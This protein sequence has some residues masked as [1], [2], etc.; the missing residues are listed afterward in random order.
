MACCVSNK[1]MMLH[2]YVPMHILSEPL[3]LYQ[4]AL[5][6]D[7]SRAL[8]NADG[9][10]PPAQANFMVSAHDKRSRAPKRGPE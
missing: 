6:A 4:K 2:T 9:G 1:V 7:V 5:S 10:P 3:I 8:S